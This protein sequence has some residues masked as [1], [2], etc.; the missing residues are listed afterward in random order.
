M[1]FSKELR[2][3]IDFRIQNSKEDG[4]ES[5]ESLELK[6]LIQDMDEKESVASEFKKELEN[7]GI[8][9]GIFKGYSKEELKSIVVFP[10]RSKKYDFKRGEVYYR[11]DKWI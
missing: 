8:E 11:F 4:E 10:A 6:Y 5:S 2:E 1:N 9:V 7:Y 3:E